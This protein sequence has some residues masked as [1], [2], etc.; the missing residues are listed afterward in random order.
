[1]QTMPLVRIHGPQDLRIDEVPQPTPGPDD[2][3]VQVMR[4]GIC[5]SDLSYAKLGGIPGAARPFA[6]GHEFSGVI[7]ACGAKVRDLQVGDRVIINPEAGDNAIG[8]DG[9]SGAFAP[10]L[11]YRNVDLDP[12]GVLRLPEALD[13]D[14]GA[15]VEPLAVGMHGINQGQIREGDRVV[16]FGAGPVGLAAAIAARYRGA[17]SVV[18]ADLSEKRLATARELGLLACNPEKADLK[19]FL[20]E[21][22]GVVTNDPLL[23]DQPGTDLFVEAT[24]AGPVFQQIC[25]LARKGARV[26]VIGVNFAPVELDMVNLLMK[27]LVITAA[28]RYP[29]EFPQVI[30]MLGSGKVDVSPLISHR[31]PL[32]RFDEAFSLA[33]KADQAVKVMIDCQS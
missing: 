24:G 1:M 8:S 19:A 29:D 2:V 7:A 33:Q 27:E 5:G 25:A 18:V 28:I 32:S 23:G 13:F 17:A 14:L 20:M 30:E 9:H 21:H 16:V 12:H 6:L 15:L 22:H 11:L 3:L 10:Y 26:V 4:C 31:Y